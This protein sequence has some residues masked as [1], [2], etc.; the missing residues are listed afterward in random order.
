MKRMIKGIILVV[1][2]G[3]G[4]EGFTGGM[5]RRG[6]VKMELFEGNPVGKAVW[7]KMWK[8]PMFK[9]GEQGTPITFGDSAQVIRR[10][11]EQI[12]GGEEGTE[13]LPIAEGDLASS[14]EGTMFLALKEYNDQF[15]DLYKMSFGPKTFYVI[16]EPVA[17][18]HV[19]KDAS[20]KYD[21]GI[22]HEH[23]F[24]RHF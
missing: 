6:R 11:I 1:I 18:R 2:M 24:S 23:A 22:E 9:E 15:G 16:G 12:Y 5:M 13:K 10:N 19:L 3:L 7:E 14:Q 21:K 4:V 20:K 17:A 8:L